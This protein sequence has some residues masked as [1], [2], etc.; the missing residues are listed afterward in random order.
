MA[1]AVQDVLVA[2]RHLQRLREERAEAGLL[3]LRVLQPG[4]PRLGVPAGRPRLHR[5]AAV[6]ATVEPSKREPVQEQPLS[7]RGRSAH[8]AL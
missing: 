8:L 1:V 5:P 2:L 3:L 6:T 4:D 7:W